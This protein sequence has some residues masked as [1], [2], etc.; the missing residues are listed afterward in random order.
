MSQLTIICDVCKYFHKV[1]FWKLTRR[2]HCRGCLCRGALERR[3]NGVGK[4]KEGTGSGYCRSSGAAL[5]VVVT[6]STLV[7]GS[8]TTS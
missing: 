8:R 2:K 6:P 5:D 3:G 7:L 4:G 1:Y